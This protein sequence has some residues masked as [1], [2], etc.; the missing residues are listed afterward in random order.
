MAGGTV[1]GAGC[2]GSACARTSAGPRTQPN[3]AVAT[4]RTIHDVTVS[5]QLLRERRTRAVYLAVRLGVEAPAAEPGGHKLRGPSGSRSPAATPRRRPAG[6][7]MTTGA[8]AA[9]ALGWARPR[10]HVSGFPLTG[11]SSLSS[12]L[13]TKGRQS[14]DQSGDSPP[15]RSNAAWASGCRMLTVIASSK[16]ARTRSRHR[17]CGCE[18]VIYAFAE[19]RTSASATSCGCV[20]MASWPAQLIFRMAKPR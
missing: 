6:S 10:Q 20:T 14:T 8:G 4:A 2:G 3:R 15:A 12:R 18:P 7:A 19:A 11:A 16:I 9:T 1:A 13:S 17:R 5:P